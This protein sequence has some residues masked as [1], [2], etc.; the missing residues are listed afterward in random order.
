MD[1]IKYNTESQIPALMTLLEKNMK[2]TDYN[3]KD[4][5]RILF[6]TQTWQMGTLTTDLPGNPTD[7]PCFCA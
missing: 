2:D 6:N 1:N 3:L 7:Y 5:L 4:F